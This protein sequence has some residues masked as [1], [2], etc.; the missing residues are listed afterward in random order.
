M[1]ENRHT[2]HTLTPIHTL[3]IIS[4][5]NQPTRSGGGNQSTQSKPL[6]H[7]ENMQT[8]CTEVQ[9]EHANH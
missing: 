2:T 3:R 9:G 4:D 8:A 5:D 7:G 6:K 1:D